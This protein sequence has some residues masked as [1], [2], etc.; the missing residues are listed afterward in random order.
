MNSQL[1]QSAQIACVN[2]P[3]FQLQLA[4]RELPADFDQPI[5]LVD[6]NDHRSTVWTVDRRASNKGIF[7][8]LRYVNAVALCP[9]LHAVSSQAQVIDRVHQQLIR[10]LL[11]FSPEVEPVFELAGT[12]YLDIRGMEHLEPDLNAW[13]QRLLDTLFEKEQLNANITIGFTRFGVLAAVHTAQAITV[14]DSISEELDAIFA[15]PLSKLNLPSRPT[16]ELDKLGIRTVGKLKS[17]PEW[18]VRARFSEELFELI[19]KAKS[20]DGKVHGVRLPKTYV[21]STDLEYVET[22]IERILKIVQHIWTPL[23]EQM[24]DLSQG[25]N[26]I[27]LR[28]KKDIYGACHTELKTSEPTLDEP[29]LMNLLRLRLDSMNLTEGITELA[30]RLTPGTLPD[31]QQGLFQDLTKSE[32]DLRVANR[33]LAR[34]CAE[35]GSNQVLIA[36]CQDSHLPEESYQWKPLDCLREHI[37]QHQRSVSIIRRVLDQPLRIATPRRALLRRVLGPYTISGFWWRKAMIRRENYFVED[38]AGSVQWVFYDHVG[39]Q[40]YARGFIQ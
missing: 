39:R 34:V 38:H 6:R 29:T 36:K 17:L 33:A 9:E 21:A 16:K 25:V 35:F 12:Y 7:P 10:H 22:D 23:L 15:T 28:M 37:P 27:Q 20:T 32:H 2:I 13:A 19:H 8:G 30:I 4:V 14:F 1:S 11:S 40:W 5:A 31:P 26:K 18:E 3:D 24:D